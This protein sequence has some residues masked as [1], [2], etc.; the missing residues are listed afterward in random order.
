MCWQP[1][2]AYCAEEAPREEAQAPSW[3]SLTY[4]QAEEKGPDLMKVEFFI[5]RG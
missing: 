1:E 3:S 5:K 4:V 2:L